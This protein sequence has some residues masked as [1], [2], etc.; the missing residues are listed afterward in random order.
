MSKTATI[1][2]NLGEWRS[3]N[4]KESEEIVS[5]NYISLRNESKQEEQTEVNAKLG[6]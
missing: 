5:Q 2:V 6:K 4:E 3:D 1:F